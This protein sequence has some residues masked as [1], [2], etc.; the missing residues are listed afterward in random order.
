[1]HLL[2]C[3]DQLRDV[4]FRRRLKHACQDNRM[5][6]KTTDFTVNGRSDDFCA[7]HRHA[8][9]RAVAWLHEEAKTM[10]DPHARRILDAA[11]HELGVLAR[12]GQAQ[13]DTKDP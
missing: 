13:N 2:P 5:T 3:P 10:N 9:R 4:P 12:N 1:V 6:R 7:G 8:L 11:A